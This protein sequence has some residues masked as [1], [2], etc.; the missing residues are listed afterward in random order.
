M[1]QK[2]FVC[3]DVVR[4]IGP[5]TKTKG[6]ISSHVGDVDSDKFNVRVKSSSSGIWYVVCCHANTLEKIGEV[7]AI[8]RY[9]SYDNWPTIKEVIQ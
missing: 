1:N 4:F 7:G 9:N 6:I 5:R 8:P 3:G 2:E